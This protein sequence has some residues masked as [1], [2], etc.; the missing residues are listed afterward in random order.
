MSFSDLTILK[1]LCPVVIALQLIGLETLP[2]I[3]QVGIAIHTKAFDGA[4]TTY[5]LFTGSRV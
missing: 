4:P 2:I 1:S 3:A 5:E